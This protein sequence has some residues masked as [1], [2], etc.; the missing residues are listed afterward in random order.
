MN[1]Y[2]VEAGKA[3]I[4]SLS[5]RTDHQEEILSNATPYENRKMDKGVAGIKI[6]LQGEKEKNQEIL[7][8]IKKVFGKSNLS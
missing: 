3:R 4:Q 8:E 2:L 1:N 5:T 6:Q 7:P